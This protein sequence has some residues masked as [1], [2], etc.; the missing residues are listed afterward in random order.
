MDKDFPLI[1]ISEL[2]ARAIK[3]KELSNKELT[4]SIQY[5]FVKD[6]SE[7]N[8][9]PIIDARD[10]DSY[11]EGHIDNAINID[12]FLIIDD[13]DEKEINKLNNFLSSNNSSNII[14]YCWNPECDRAEYLQS[15]L[16]DIGSQL[17]VSIYEDGWD[18]WV[19]MENN[20]E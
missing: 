11:N 7:N 16:I 4:N 17:K 18:D 20:N 10:F 15:Y 8:I 19:L 5:S 9:Y 12:A 3:I 2:Q 13:G 1:G 6:I 14:I